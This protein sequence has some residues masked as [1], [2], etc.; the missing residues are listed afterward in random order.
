MNNQELLSFSRTTFIIRPLTQKQLSPDYMKLY[1]SMSDHII[2][3]EHTNIASTV[4]CD[5]LMS[6]INEI[7]TR[8]QHDIM[9]GSINSRAKHIPKVPK[10]V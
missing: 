6:H 5:S 10:M 7:K 1:L 4:L 8:Y 9:L 3:L 2:Y